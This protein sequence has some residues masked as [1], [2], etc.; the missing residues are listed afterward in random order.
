MLPVDEVQIESL[1][2]SDI[3]LGKSIYTREQLD[4]CFVSRQ[5]GHEELAYT[6][7]DEHGELG[8]GLGS[9]AQA[10]M[11]DIIGTRFIPIYKGGQHLPV[12]H[13][14]ATDGVGWI[15]TRSYSL[16]ESH[17]HQKI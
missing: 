2:M 13:V 7:R 11:I 4:E 9:Q 1:W 5:P 10:S 3:S 15:L 14:P 6:R 17:H 8:L 12:L 16:P